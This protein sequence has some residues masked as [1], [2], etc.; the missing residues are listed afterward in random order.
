VVA[1]CSSLVASMPARVWYT[2]GLA[3]CAGAQPEE[4]LPLSLPNGIQPVDRRR[5]RD[6]MEIGSLGMTP[7]VGTSARLGVA[8]V[9]HA[10]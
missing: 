8:P 9:D 1:S 5:R 2:F 7:S 4:R 6:W 10:L 3:V